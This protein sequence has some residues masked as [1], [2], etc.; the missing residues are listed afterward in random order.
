[1]IKSAHKG[2]SIMI[3]SLLIV[4]IVIAAGVVF[5]ASPKLSGFILSDYP[6]TLYSGESF[7]TTVTAVD[8]FG[9]P[10]TKADTAIYFH[11]S[12]TKAVIPQPGTISN[13]YTFTSA[14]NGIH[15]FSGFSLISLDSSTITVTNGEKSTTSNIIKVNAVPIL[16]HFD[17]DPINS[18]V[19]A[20][21]NF[22]IKIT[23]LDQYGEIMDSY[24][25]TPML[26]YS[27]G[28]I[29]PN[30][31]TSWSN[32]VGTA[33]VKIT[34][35]GNDVSITVKDASASGTSN[36]FDVIASTKPSFIVDAPLYTGVDKPFPV[37]VIPIIKHDLDVEYGYT[38]TIHFSSN[39]KSVSLPDDY[40]FVTGDY[41]I[42]TFTVTCNVS[43]TVTINVNDVQ[44]PSRSGS[45]TRIIHGE[46]PS[47]VGFGSC[48]AD[49]GYGVD[50][51]IDPT[52]PPGLQADDL[53]L[54]QV[55]GTS[56]Y[57]PSPPNDFE[58][59]YGPDQ[60]GVVS[61]WIYYRFADGTESGQK[62]LVNYYAHC[63]KAA[64]MW[65]FRNVA[66]TD[67]VEGSNFTSGTSAVME[68]SSV[69]TT[70]IDHLAIAFIFIGTPSSGNLGFEPLSSPPE[71][72]WMEY[73]RYGE[74]GGR[75]RAP[76]GPGPTFYAGYC[77]YDGANNPSGIN[78][79]SEMLT[80]SMD[81]PRTKSPESFNMTQSGD[82]GVRA[83]GLIPL[84]PKRVGN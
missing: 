55:V 3:A 43:K 14:D 13:P 82:W 5:Y 62:I 69:T 34:T 35:I 22:D 59:L 29:E 16:D 83:F 63:T 9:R 19:N 66:L 80:A 60:V 17:F 75:W 10:F 53:I 28:S 6:T 51:Y 52:Y 73:L 49:Y 15:T 61:Q 25:G 54:L 56:S 44:E 23:A 79:W 76:M 50:H 68:M 7:S 27:Q 70:D 32:G 65:A 48:R 81:N 78:L 47:L 57:Q 39:D 38:G 30:I 8:Q 71:I 11:S 21:E 40:T 74:T 26:D 20:G 64:R 77:A 67:F 18:P 12:D 42:H 37:T 84:R 46:P 72:S 31:V 24:S 36:S 4:G 58:L 41:G 2:V 33:S 45:L 1:M